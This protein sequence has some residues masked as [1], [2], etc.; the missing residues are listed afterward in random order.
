MKRI[1]PADPLRA[2]LRIEPESEPGSVFAYNNGATYTLGAILQDRTGQSLTG[3]LQPRLFDPLGIAPP[4]WDTLGPRQMGFSGVHLTT[5]QLAR[6]AQLY[7]QHGSWSG[8]S[9]LPPGWVAEATRVHTANPGEPEPDWQRGYG[10]QFWRSRHG[11]RADGAFG[12][13]AL[14][15]PEQDVVVVMTGETETMQAVLD[16]VWDHLIPAFDGSVSADDDDRLADR[17]ASLNLPVEGAGTYPADDWVTSCVLTE[18]PDGWDL[19]M[20]DPDQRLVVGCGNRR[21][22][23]SAVPVG[24]DLALAVE[25]QGRWVDSE[26]FTAELVFV[27]TPHRMTVTLTPRTGSSSARWRTVPLRTPSLVGLATPS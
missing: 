18:R 22:Q 19:M 8:S 26:T 14:V 9:V 1:D 24:G 15:L 3:Y 17:L 5:E 6:F 4:H 11:Y 10:Y 21:W 20:T 12:Q 2:F 23:R 27:H 7:L 16:A 25:A 13:F